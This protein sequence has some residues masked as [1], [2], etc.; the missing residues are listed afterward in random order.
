MKTIIKTVAKILKRQRGFTLV[1]M[2]TVIAIMGVMAAVAVPMVSSQL[3]K[4]REKSYLQDKAM[5]QTSV[6]SFF[7]A[8]DNE[9]FLG[10]RQYPLL[11]VGVDKLNDDWTQS[12][13]K[14][15]GKTVLDKDGNVVVTGLQAE[16]NLT[17]LGNPLRGTKGGLPKWRDSLGPGL[18][19]TDDNRAL[20]N[21]ELIP[22]TDNRSEE[23]L[24]GEFETFN[25]LRLTNFNLPKQ[26]DDKGVEISVPF[27]TQLNDTGTA[28]RTPL[29]KDASGGW[30]VDKVSFQSKD[31][32]VDSRNYFIDFDLLVKAGLLQKTPD[33]ASRDNGGGEDSRGSYSWFVTESGQV[34][35]LFFFFPSNGVGF[36][37]ETLDGT[38]DLRGFFVGVY[39]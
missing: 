1:E 14:D 39:P 30:Y 2:V 20:I 34:E 12:V 23:N 26:K 36:D 4:T 33:S 10:Q 6:D 9:R 22:L 29:L 38:L 31:F 5:I 27:L 16:D 13:L 32:A 18:S 24:N 25:P 19:G 17:I 21:D 8:A 28:T 11:G 7:T 35:S 15:A 3:S 37:G